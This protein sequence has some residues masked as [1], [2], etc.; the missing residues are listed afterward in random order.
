[1]M[2]GTQGTAGTPGHPCPHWEQ[3]MQPHELQDWQST[4]M[5]RDPHHGLRPVPGG[6]GF[7]VDE[8]GGWAAGSLGT[9]A[10]RFWPR[11]EAA[12]QPEKAPR[13]WVRSV[14]VGEPRGR[15]TPWEP[16]TQLTRGRGLGVLLAWEG[17]ASPGGRRGGSR[18]PA[19]RLARRLFGLFGSGGERP[20]GSRDGDALYTGNTCLMRDTRL[21]RQAGTRT[22]ATETPRLTQCRHTHAQLPLH[23]DTSTMLM[24]GRQGGALRGPRGHP[25][26]G[27]GTPSIPAKGTGTHFS[28]R[29]GACPHG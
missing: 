29:R 22:G 16:Q 23:T 25:G 24:A 20:G 6:F 28:L 2:H 10:K 4:C 18:L 21:P 14:R 11:R 26:W 9:F 13:C 8:D 27:W 19:S 17:R 1:M 7:P 3:E 5:T 15:R 12:A